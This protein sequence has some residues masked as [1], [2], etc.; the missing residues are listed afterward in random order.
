LVDKLFVL[1]P[2][3]FGSLFYWLFVVVAGLV[4]YQRLR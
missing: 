1:V 3:V 2:A 4:G